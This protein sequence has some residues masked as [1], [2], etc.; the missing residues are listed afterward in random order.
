MVAALEPALI[1]LAK[2]TFPS[3]AV[4]VAESEACANQGFVYRERVG[5]GAPAA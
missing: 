5:G 4:H 3:G 2:I 1:P